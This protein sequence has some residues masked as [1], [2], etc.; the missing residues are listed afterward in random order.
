MR[1]CATGR[2]ARHAGCPA[3][4][5]AVLPAPGGAACRGRPGGCRPLRADGAGRCRRCDRHGPVRG[6]A[7]AVGAA[8]GGLSRVPLEGCRSI[9]RA[10]RSRH[11]GPCPARR[12]ALPRRVRRRM[13]QARPRRGSSAPTGPA[14]RETVTS[15]WR[16]LPHRPRGPPADPVEALRAAG[17]AP[18]PGT[19]GWRSSGP[20]PSW[21][22]AGARRGQ[23]GRLGHP[24]RGGLR[25]RRTPSARRGSASSPLF[26]ESG[27]AYPRQAGS[28]VPHGRWGGAG[29]RTGPQRQSGNSKSTNR[30]QDPYGLVLLGCAIPHPPLMESRAAMISRRT[31]STRYPGTPAGRA[32]PQHVLAIT[33]RAPSRCQRSWAARCSCRRPPT[34]RT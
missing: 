32:G 34:W 29:G 19:A 13:D 6:R 11:R 17:A 24:C 7:R 16:T 5:A 31:P 8:L 27:P 15:C 21:G 30:V 23:A 1:C 14:P 20:R 33:M 10:A 26:D 28:V 3:D 2:R 18:C 12:R 4:P 9:R 22:A 25:V